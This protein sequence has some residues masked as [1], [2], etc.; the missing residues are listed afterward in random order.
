MTSQCYFTEFEEHAN[1]FAQFLRL[2]N[3]DILIIILTANGDTVYVFCIIKITCET[4]NH[5]FFITSI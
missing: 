2:K 5:E 4:N 3:F 1:K